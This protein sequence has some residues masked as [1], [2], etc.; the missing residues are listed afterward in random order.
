MIS[1]KKGNKVAKFVLTA[2]LAASLIIPTV[3]FAADPESTTV[4]G[5]GN[6]YVTGESYPTVITLA[7]YNSRDKEMYNNLTFE[8]TK[9]VTAGQTATFNYYVEIFDAAGNKIGNVGTETTPETVAGAAGATTASVNNK[10][11]TLSA[12]LTSQFKIVAI[13]TSVTIN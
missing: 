1:L 3:A 5:V 4:E 11:I 9:T 6:Y 8:T 2:A 10:E 13:V 7:G 12:S